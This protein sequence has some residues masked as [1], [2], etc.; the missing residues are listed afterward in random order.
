LSNILLS[1]VLLL[2]LILLPRSR[3][4]GTLAGLIANWR[5]LVGKRRDHD[6]T[7][8]A[9]WT[10]HSSTLGVALRLAATRHQH[11]KHE[12]R[13]NRSNDSS[14]DSWLSEPTS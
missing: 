13:S 2:P 10:R 14:S 3:P 1:R 12:H 7:T 9:G 5:R 11:R 4:V 6:W 8:R